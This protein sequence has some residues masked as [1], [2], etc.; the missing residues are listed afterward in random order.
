[1]TKLKLGATQEDKPAKLSI[2]LPAAMHRM[3]T[4]GA[5]AKARKTCGDR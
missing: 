3:K 1:M 4:N 5:F 2:E